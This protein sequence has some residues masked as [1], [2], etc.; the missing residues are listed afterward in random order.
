MCGLKYKDITGEKVKKINV[1]TNKWSLV[2]PFAMFLSFP[3]NLIWY[4]YSLGNKNTL[5]PAYYHIFQSK[6]I[7]HLSNQ[8]PK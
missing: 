2:L 1:V 3:D 6:S 7:A 4:V 5:K 8:L